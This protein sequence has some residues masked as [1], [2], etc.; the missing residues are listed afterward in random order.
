MTG[1]KKTPLFYDNYILSQNK[2]IK[3]EKRKKA[4]KRAFHP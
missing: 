3:G 1:H 4:L 2:E